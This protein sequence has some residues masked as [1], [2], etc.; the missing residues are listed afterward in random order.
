MADFK[1]DLTDRVYGEFCPTCRA[2]PG[3][4]CVYANVPRLVSQPYPG[5]HHSRDLVAAG[6]LDEKGNYLLRRHP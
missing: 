4:P 2:S 5:T 1:P 3:E 6:V